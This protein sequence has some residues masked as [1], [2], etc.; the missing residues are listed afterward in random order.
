VPKRKEEPQKRQV[1][2]NESSG[3]KCGGEGVDKRVLPK[4]T[5]KSK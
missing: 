3:L 5:G 2:N 4:D 1:Q